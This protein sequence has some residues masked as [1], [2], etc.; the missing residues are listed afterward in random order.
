MCRPRWHRIQESSSQRRGHDV[1]SPRLPRRAVEAAA[2][3]TVPFVS[4][5]G[6]HGTRRGTV[7]VDAT[8]YATGGDLLSRATD[9]RACG[10]R[11]SACAAHRVVTSQNVP[12]PPNATRRVKASAP[13]AGAARGPAR[14]AALKNL[15]TWAYIALPGSRSSEMGR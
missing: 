3:R 10:P 4:S 14:S 8:R 9:L 1:R 6:M 15:W 5:A 7:I 13:Q 2:E 12:F 11:K